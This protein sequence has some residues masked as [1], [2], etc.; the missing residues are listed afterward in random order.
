MSIPTRSNH[1]HAFVGD[2][3]ASIAVYRLRE[4]K[5]A[6]HGVVANG[7]NPEPRPC[8]FPYVL[9]LGNHGFRQGTFYNIL[10]PFTIPHY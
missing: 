7:D 4:A 1:R 2:D 5:G 8:S 6:H 3:S 9:E 10:I